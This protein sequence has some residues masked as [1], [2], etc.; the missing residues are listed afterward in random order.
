MFEGRNGCAVG[1]PVHDV[2]LFRQDENRAGGKCALQGDSDAGRGT[3]HARGVATA[4]GTGRAHLRGLF[5]LPRSAGRSSGMV[6][7]R[8]SLVTTESCGAHVVKGVR[9]RRG[10]VS[11][12]PLIERSAHVYTGQRLRKATADEQ[13]Q[14]ELA[15]TRN[16]G[17][18]MRDLHRVVN[19]AS[20]LL[21]SFPAES[22][23]AGLPRL[24][25][26]G[27]FPRQKRE[28]RGSRLAGQGC[29]VVIGSGDPHGA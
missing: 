1:R 14:R 27:C 10:V 12:R 13:K 2:K 7:R 4:T 6:T 8:A 20:I 9:G 11:I 19:P 17:A 3:G 25:G 29:R 23:S 5:R 18:S 15:C 26:L 16:H 22:P 28:H 21:H 24:R